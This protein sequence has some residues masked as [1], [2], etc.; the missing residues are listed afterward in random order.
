M[1]GPEHSVRD[2]LATQLERARSDPHAVLVMALMLVATAPSDDDEFGV[3]G[4]VYAIID[5]YGFDQHDID[6]AEVEVREF[7]ARHG[8]IE[9]RRFEHS[10]D[11]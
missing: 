8:L 3:L 10:P 4:D 1:N 9:R 2:E 6:R 7:M 11:P 5:R